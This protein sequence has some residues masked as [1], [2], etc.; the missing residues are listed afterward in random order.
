MMIIHNDP[1]PYPQHFSATKTQYPST[2]RH[3]QFLLEFSSQPET[4]QTYN[5]TQV[6]EPHLTE[7]ETTQRRHHEENKSNE[8][9]STISSIASAFP[10]NVVS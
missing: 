2:G 10:D 1:K 7:N 8:K 6:E 9:L 4:L 3:N 5:T